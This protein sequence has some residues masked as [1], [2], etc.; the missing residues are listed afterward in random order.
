MLESMPY[1]GQTYNTCYILFC[2]EENGKVSTRENAII[3]HVIYSLKRGATSRHRRAPP[4]VFRSFVTSGNCE[5][6]KYLRNP[7]SLSPKVKSGTF[8]IAEGHSM[9]ENRFI[10]SLLSSYF[11][12]L[13]ISEH[14]I[15]FLMAPLQEWPQPCASPWD[16]AEWPQTAFH[17]LISACTHETV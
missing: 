17:W 3:S 15:A 4:A 10:L 12:A 6:R 8:H 13:N 1:L 9:L 7:V 2:H 11:T 14:S 5:P 16:Y